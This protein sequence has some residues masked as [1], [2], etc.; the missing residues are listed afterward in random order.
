MRE[1]DLFPEMEAVCVTT[2][3]N[4]ARGLAA[5]QMT[6]WLRPPK[7]RQLKLGLL[8]TAL[9]TVYS[10]GLTPSP[11]PIRDEKVF[12]SKDSPFSSSSS[13]H[14]SNQSSL[15][16]GSHFLFLPNT[17]Q[18]VGAQAFAFPPTLTDR[19]FHFPSLSGGSFENG[20]E[21][22]VSSVSS[23]KSAGTD[24]SYCASPSALYG[25]LQE[26][27]GRTGGLRRR[28][29]SNNQDVEAVAA[30]TAHFTG[31]EKIGRRL[32]AFSAS[33]AARAAHAP[34]VE[35]GDTLPSAKVWDVAN[36]KAVDIRDVFRMDSHGTGRAVLFAVPGAYTPVC[37]ETHLPS[38]VK[39]LDEMK[40]K[41][42][43][44]ACI[45]VND[46]FVMKAWSKSLRVPPGLKML[47]D[48]N[49]VLTKALGMTLDASS[50]FMGERSK[51]FAIIVGPNWKVEW[52]GKEEESFA[53]TVMTALG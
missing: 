23:P 12:F 22:P 51:R 20:I 49:G 33:G 14:F 44:V 38:F 43:V 46:P 2:T 3:T 36:D 19:V 21:F 32:S 50:F 45:A 42:D 11:A 39:R 26:R 15:L 8:L 29:V 30:E 31:G 52:V 28:E 10:A 4:A 48:G 35:A 40:T 24:I 13:H 47:S 37:S 9:V 25:K 18:I 53:D 17:P 6:C 34:E 1:E 16:P 27:R 41:A 5:R 7:S